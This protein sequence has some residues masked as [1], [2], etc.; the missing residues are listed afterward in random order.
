LGVLLANRIAAFDYIGGSVIGS[1]VG[2][3]EY[4]GKGGTV[5][6]CDRV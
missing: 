5:T 2:S 6:V 3:G 1:A 4:S